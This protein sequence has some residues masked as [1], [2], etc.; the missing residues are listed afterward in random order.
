MGGARSG[1]L[2]GCAR[3]RAQ[4]VLGEACGECQICKLGSDA[5]RACL[6][7]RAKVVT[8]GLCLPDKAVTHPSA[9]GALK[10]FGFGTGDGCIEIRE[11]DGEERG[12]V[13]AG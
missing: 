3:G 6:A 12:F 11:R 1:C 10:R 5:E 13:N 8:T 9:S 7:G 2:R 4:T